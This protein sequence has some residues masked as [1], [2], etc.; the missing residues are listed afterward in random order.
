MNVRLKRISPE[1]LGLFLGAAGFVVA[2]PTVIFALA[3]IGPGRTVS[4]NGFVS[5]TFMDRLDPVGLVLAYPILNATVGFV[6]GLLV[7]WFYNFLA[8]FRGGIRIRLNERL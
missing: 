7:G 2:V 8:R 3:F 1:D 6:A 4:L 5:L